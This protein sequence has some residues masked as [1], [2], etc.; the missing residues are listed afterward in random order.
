MNWRKRRYG[1]TAF[2]SLVIAFLMSSFNVKKAYQRCEEAE[3]Q[4][5]KL[6]QE[7]SQR[8]REIVDLREEGTLVLTLHVW[9]SN[10]LTVFC[11]F[12]Q[13]NQ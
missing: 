12:R 4:M 10:D 11:A 7:L 2:P 13:P 8:S 9:C 6:H 1:C 5:Q 3:R